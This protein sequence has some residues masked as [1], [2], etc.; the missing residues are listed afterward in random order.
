MLELTEHDDDEVTEGFMDVILSTLPVTRLMGVIFM[1]MLEHKRD[2]LGVVFL[3]VAP[4]SSSSGSSMTRA[5]S[6]KSSSLSQSPSSSSCS[7]AGGEGEEDDDEDDGD[8]DDEEGD[9]GGGEPLALLALRLLTVSFHS[10][11]SLSSKWELAVAVMMARSMARARSSLLVLSL[12]H[13]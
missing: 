2:R 13:I 3:P 7:E 8:D 4:R 12:I 10:R 11:I 5:S 6:S 9:E 1:V